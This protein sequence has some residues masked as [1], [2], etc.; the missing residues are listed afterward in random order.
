MP[1]PGVALVGSAVR[2]FWG[3]DEKWYEGRVDAWDARSGTHHITYTDGDK[4]WHRLSHPA[5]VWEITRPPA[6]GAETSERSALG[7]AR[8]KE[9][10]IAARVGGSKVGEG[11]VVR[12]V[13]LV[14]EEGEGKSA[15]SWWLLVVSVCCR[16][17][18][19]GR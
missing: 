18:L 19:F 13:I 10:D 9:A 1:F 15:M 6:S 17:F 7:R 5:E 8:D 12:Q 14:R 4:K 2:V 16:E 11:E 3:G